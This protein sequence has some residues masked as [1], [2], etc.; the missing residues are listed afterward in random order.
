MIF[1]FNTDV[2]CGDLV[3]HVQSEARKAEQLL[4]TQVFVRGRCLGKHAVSYAEQA[5]RADFSE[6]VMHEL[7]KEQHRRIVEATRDGQV[8]SVIQVT[9]PAAAAAAAPASHTSIQG[10]LAINKVSSSVQE[11]AVVLKFAITDGGHPVAG[12]ELAARLEHPAAAP[13]ESKSTTGADGAAEVTFAVTRAV[14]AEGVITL[15]ATHGAHTVTR[16]IRPRK[17]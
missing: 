10:G 14:L 16:H 7:L 9:D 3:Y 6:D 4:Q 5:A 1:G 12:A 15:Q 13:L 11:G 2:K 8:A 17:A